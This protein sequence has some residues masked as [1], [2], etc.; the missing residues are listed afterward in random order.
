VRRLGPTTDDPY[1][2]A[3]SPGAKTLAVCGYSGQVTAW[4]L[5]GDKPTFTR[6]IKNPGYC[7]VFT[8]DGKAV[9]TG[10][11]N[12]TVAVTPLKE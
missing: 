11:D 7:I 8:P 5:D 4:A 1:A 6:A 9:L 2:L 12:G 10:H 3:W